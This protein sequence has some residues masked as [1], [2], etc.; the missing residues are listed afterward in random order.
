MEMVSQNHR[1]ELIR[2]FC[3]IFC[4]HFG[5]FSTYPRA[6]VTKLHLFHLMCRFSA[7]LSYAMVVLYQ[8]M[9]QL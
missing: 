2:M 9:I 5:A 7:I 1:D 6:H 8:I 4:L 3:I